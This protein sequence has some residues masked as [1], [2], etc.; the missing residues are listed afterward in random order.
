MV[1]LAAAVRVVRRG[2]RGEVGRLQEGRVP[3]YARA[4]T[5]LSLACEL[6]VVGSIGARF[7][8]LV[9]VLGRLLVRS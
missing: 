3:R 4:S 8:G 1:L 6:V 2:L 7:G 9:G 5:S